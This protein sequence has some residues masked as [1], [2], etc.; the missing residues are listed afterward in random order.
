METRT[1]TPSP[2]V[3]KWW[4]LAMVHMSM[5]AYALNLQM[6][7]PV[8]PILISELGLSHTQAGV[9][10]GLFTLPGIFLAIPGGRVSDAIGPRSVALWSLAMLS[11]GAILMLPL[12]PGFLYTGRLCSGIGGAVIVVVAPQII[13]RNFHGR[14][15]GL[16]MGIFNT[17]V[18][19]GTILAFNLL[20]FFAGRLGIPVVIMGTASFTLVI[21]TAFYLTY[22]DSQTASDNVPVAAP[23][24]LK[25]LGTGIWIV[26][27]VWV[28]F[29]ISILSYFTYAID[30]FTNGGMDG[31]KAR[32]LS[33][34]PMLLS[35]ILTPLA[36]FAIH[37]YGLKRSLLVLG[38]AVSSAAILLVLTPDRNM[39]L[40]WSILLGAGISM[41]PPAVF[42]I[43][44]EVVPFSMVG[45]GFGLLTTVFNLGIFFGIPL[46]GHI[47]DLTTTYTL[48][49]IL[50][51]LIMFMGAFIAGISGRLLA[52]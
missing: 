24:T 39:I 19:L 35:I 25:G 15:L 18:P 12:H 27:L 16:A 38:C 30:H 2:G 17:A 22:A 14:E 28:L 13:A 52:N 6:I 45:T 23:G 11:A 31:A 7:P 33:S 43:A 41:V 48:S 9:L 51:S 50:M 21:L 36:G 3:S 37:R 46:I 20:G 4:V 49:F 8:L 29:N 1:S 34:L 32:F 5:M 10:M 44:G 40:V 47:R 42:T 26:S